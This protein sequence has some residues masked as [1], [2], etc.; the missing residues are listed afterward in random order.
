[1]IIN[2]ISLIFSYFTT[3]CPPSEKMDY[4]IGRTMFETDRL[5]DGWV[6][7]LNYMDEIWVPTSHSAD[8]FK[9]SGLHPDKVII[10]GEPVD[11]EFF[12]PITNG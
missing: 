1:M 9:A 2:L 8:I 12:M 11:T 10:V 5:P 6:N 3:N 7:R 4:K